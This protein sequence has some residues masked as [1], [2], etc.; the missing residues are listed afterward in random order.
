MDVPANS[1][2]SGPITSIFSAKSF[3]GDPFI[4]QCEKEDKKAQGFPIL[5]LCGSFSSEFVA[6]KGLKDSRI[7]VVSSASNLSCIQCF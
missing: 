7:M 4:C 2:F 1:I 6:V 3:D 5:P